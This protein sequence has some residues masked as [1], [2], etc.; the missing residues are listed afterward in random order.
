M[1]NCWCVILL[2]H[3]HNLLYKRCCIKTNIEHICT[4]IKC[5]LCFSCDYCCKISLLIESETKTDSEN[6]NHC[7]KEIKD[8]ETEKDQNCPDLKPED[9]S[10]PVIT[11]HNGD[12]SDVESETEIVTNIALVMEKRKYSIEVVFHD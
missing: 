6:T 12:V 10:Y 4:G 2:F 11:P 1:V 7:E 8:T 9:K 3:K 5:L